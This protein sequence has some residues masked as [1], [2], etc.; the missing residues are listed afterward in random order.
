MGG[1]WW[2]EGGKAVEGGEEGLGGVV[3]FLLRP[4]C[5]KS[6]GSLAHVA[7][8][9]TGSRLARAQIWMASPETHPGNRK[10]PEGHLLLSGAQIWMPATNAAARGLP[11]AAL[12]PGRARAAA[13]STS[14]AAA[15]RNASSIEGA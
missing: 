2:R 1:R 9:T 8:G 15:G 13:A 10:T 14:A 5:P 4:L 6:Q 7:K 3:P 11:C 12:E